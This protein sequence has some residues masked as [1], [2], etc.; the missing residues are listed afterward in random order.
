[1][2][3]FSKGYLAVSSSS[4]SILLPHLSRK[5]SRVFTSVKGFFFSSEPPVWNQGQKGQS[6]QDS[7]TEQRKDLI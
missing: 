1:M 4:Q 7:A 6:E 5:Q 2:Y 3:L